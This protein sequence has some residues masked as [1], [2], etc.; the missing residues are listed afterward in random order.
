VGLHIADL[1]EGSTSSR[2][3]LA[4]A[5]R[6]FKRSLA[7]VADSGASAA[8]ASKVFGPLLKSYQEEIDSL[9]KRAK[10]SEVAFLD[11]YQQLYEVGGTSSITV[12]SAMQGQNQQQYCQQ[13]YKVGHAG[14]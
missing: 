4:D 13:L 14:S 3:K 8:E 6:E 12:A 2:R 11:L 9:T 5:T 10:Y 7:T 1:Q